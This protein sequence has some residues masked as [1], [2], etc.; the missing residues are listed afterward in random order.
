MKIKDL[1]V[2][3]KIQDHRPAFTLIELLV[4]I[5]IIGVLATISMISINA[6]RSRARDARRLSDMRS[7]V[8]AIE[9]YYN[10]YGEYPDC[11]FG[12]DKMATGDSSDYDGDGIQEYGWNE[13]LGV[14]L[15]P[16][17]SKLPSDPGGGQYTYQQSYRNGG[18]AIQLLFS[19]ENASPNI[20]N[21]KLIGIS[22]YFF[23]S[24]LV[25]QYADCSSNSCD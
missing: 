8:T 9:M 5:A 2:S 6:V 23:Y 21:A 24:I 13:C 11:L 7:L 19:L 17:M 3:K 15:R 20:S 1:F 18:N 25:Q 22:H 14:K 16:Y 12:C 10:D 4:V